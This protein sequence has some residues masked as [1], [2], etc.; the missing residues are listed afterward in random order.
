MKNKLELK[1]IDIMEKILEL[2]IQMEDDVKK[3]IELQNKETEIEEM[4]K[5]ILTTKV[6][7]KHMELY[8]EMEKI[9]KK[10]LLKKDGEA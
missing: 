1:E 3:Y 8:E 9:I 4:E 10:G 7:I 6:M 5:I 2:L